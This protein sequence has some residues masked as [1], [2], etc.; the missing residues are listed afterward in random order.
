[1][2]LDACA[3]GPLV[4]AMRIATAPDAMRKATMYPPATAAI[5][6]KGFMY[7][8][9]RARR[10]PHRSADFLAVEGRAEFT[11]TISTS[12]KS[13]RFLKSRPSGASF[14]R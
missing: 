12:S 4:F 13:A 6:R 11:V 8:R 9:G 3:S 14:T 2:P 1:M 5:F 7:V 10:G